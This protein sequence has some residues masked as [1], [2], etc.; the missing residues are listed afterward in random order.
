MKQNSH[1]SAS[2]VAEP[3]D[4]APLAD[5][6]RIRIATVFASI[7]ISGEPSRM[8]HILKNLDRERFDHFLLT[9]AKPNDGEQA[10]GTA[11]QRYRD[12]G[13][14]LLDLGEERWSAGVLRLSPLKLL[15]GIWKL[16]RTVF[17][18][19]A[20][21]RR[22]RIDVLDLH[23][24]SP[25]FIGA[26]AGRLARVPVIV[27]TAY[28]PDF[29]D[30][31]I[32]RHLGRFAFR[33]ADVFI[34]DSQA[35]CDEINRWLGRP[36]RRSVVLK[37]GVVPPEP[38]RSASEVAKELGIE[39]RPDIKIVGQISR[40]EPRKGQVVLLQAARLV[41]DAVPNTRFLLCGFVS[42]WCPEDYQ[43]QLR[44]LSRELGIEKHVTILSYPG[45]IGDIWQLIDV[46][47]HA[48]MMDS[49]P[50]S[51][52]EGMSVGKPAVVTDE[53]GIPELILHEETGLVVPQGDAEA[54]A[55]GL[56][57]L[58]TDATLAQRFSER[59]Q[60]R[61]RELHDPAAMTR[62]LENVFVEALREKQPFRET[63]NG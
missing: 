24:E 41:I 36:L 14:E 55:S 29:W 38:R 10:H 23:S 50:M 43:E 13:I 33:T 48:S 32:W 30:R 26:L 25:I 59:T 34:T 53:G 56:I 4:G 39:R 8:L 11:R 16:I 21:L 60:Q 1:V 62:L 35:Q 42:P 54:M 20:F 15:G 52:I 31:P 63:R 37:N 7:Y 6:R 3:L 28:F 12:A 22:N 27:S 9:I 51:V 19:A 45:E 17:K 58:L 61:Y 40:M 46:Q 49:S 5:H 18:L 2:S 47:A 57:R 44:A